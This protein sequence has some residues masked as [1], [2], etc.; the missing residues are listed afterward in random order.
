MVDST[1]DVLQRLQNDDGET[2]TNMMSYDESQ[3]MCFSVGQD[4]SQVWLTSSRPT[5]LN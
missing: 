2:N 4:D 5:A 1:G 3:N